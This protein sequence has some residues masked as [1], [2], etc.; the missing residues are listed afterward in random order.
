MS[1]FVLVIHAD[2]QFGFMD[3]VAAEVAAGFRAL[4]YRSIATHPLDA[5]KMAEASAIIAKDGI[6]MA[7][8]MNGVGMDLADEDFSTFLKSLKAPVVGFFLDH[9]AYHSSRISAPLPHLRLASSCSHDGAFIRRFLRDDVPVEHI[10]HG[11]TPPPRGL[12]RPWDERDIDVLVP[13]TMPVHPDLERSTWATRYGNLT[14]AQLNAIIEVHDGAPAQ[15]LHEAILYVLGD[16]AVSLREMLPYYLITDLYLR[17][18]VKLDSVRALLDRNV[19]V[20][21]LS[22]GWPDDLGGRV[23]RLPSVPLVEGFA[24]MGRSKMVLNHLPSYFESHERPLQ[25]AL[26]GAVAASTPSEWVDRVMGGHAVMLPLSMQD[27]ATAVA[28]ALVDPA[29]PERAALGCAAVENGQLWRDRAAELAA[30]R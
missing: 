30:L 6:G 24:L 4:G 12:V 29:L 3:G 28:T 7:I 9:P 2:S 17:A 10:H 25:A 22:S 18:R 16:R 27:A 23:T 15:P 21:V 8:L 26:C 20:T 5:R 13:S 11:A 19:P 14:A 1:D